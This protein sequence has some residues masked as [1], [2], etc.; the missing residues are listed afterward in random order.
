[1]I[2]LHADPDIK[3]DN[4]MLDEPQEDRYPAY[5]TPKMIDF[6]L[7]FPLGKYTDAIT[8]QECVANQG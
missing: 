3:P 2:F 8:K 1:V 5:K 6:G 7:C 4:V